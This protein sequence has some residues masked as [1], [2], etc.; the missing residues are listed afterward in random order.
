[1]KYYRSSKV[2]ESVKLCWFRGDGRGIC[3]QED[4]EGSLP[5]K[6]IVEPSPEEGSE[7]T[8]FQAEGLLQ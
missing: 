6:V 2:G 5:E 1:M 4:D 3:L 8:V 7:K